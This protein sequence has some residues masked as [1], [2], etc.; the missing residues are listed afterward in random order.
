M[1]K[2]RGV[3]GRVWRLAELAELNLSPAQDPSAPGDSG[4]RE[5]ANLPQILVV[6]GGLEPWCDHAVSE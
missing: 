3:M 1:E 4:R 6:A 5:A 2:G